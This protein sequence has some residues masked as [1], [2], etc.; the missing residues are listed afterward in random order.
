MQISVINHTAIADA[1]LQRVLRAVNRQIES[2]FA[3][4]GLGE[5]AL[6]PVAPAVGNAVYAA[7]G[8]RIQAVPLVPELVWKE[9][10]NG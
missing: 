4:T 2:D 8:V 9:I 7:T 10:E 6:P 3:P 1:E 5:P